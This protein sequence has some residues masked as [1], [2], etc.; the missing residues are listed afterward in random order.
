MFASGAERGTCRAHAGRS[1]VVRDELDTLGHRET[2]SQPDPCARGPQRSGLILSEAA[3][4]P[5]RLSATVPVRPDSCASDGLH[6][7]LGS[8]RVN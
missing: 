5:L 1:R 2:E 4:A 7:W 8:N 3:R 6:L